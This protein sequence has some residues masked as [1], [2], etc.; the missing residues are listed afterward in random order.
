MGTPK[1]MILNNK[2]KRPKRLDL[3]K[4]QNKRGLLDRALAYIK[5]L[6]K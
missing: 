3:A 4:L 2:E 1:I 5:G 6:I